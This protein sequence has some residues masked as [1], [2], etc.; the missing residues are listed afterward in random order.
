[1]LQ[2]QEKGLEV[3]I[4]IVIEESNRKYQA[5]TQPYRWVRQNAINLV[6]HFGNKNIVVSPCTKSEYIAIT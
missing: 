2:K 3:V 5:K 4:P 1:M 6:Q